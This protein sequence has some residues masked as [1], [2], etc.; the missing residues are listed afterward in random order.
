MIEE[1]RVTYVKLIKDALWKS[2]DLQC[3]IISNVFNEFVA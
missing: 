3:K 2:C 1:K